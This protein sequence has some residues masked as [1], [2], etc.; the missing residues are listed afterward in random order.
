VQS[1]HGLCTWAGLGSPQAQHRYIVAPHLLSRCVSVL[2]SSSRT[3]RTTAAVTQR[4]Q[5][6]PITTAALGQAY[7][8][9]L[10]VTA[11]LGFKIIVNKVVSCAKVINVRLLGPWPWQFHMP[12]HT[13]RTDLHE[14]SSSSSSKC[15]QIAVQCCV[16]C[17]AVFS[18]SI[19]MLDLEDVADRCAVQVLVRRCCLQIYT[20]AHPNSAAAH[21]YTAQ[22]VCARG[23]ACS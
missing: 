4:S 17:F 18:A 9:R 15:K 5:R 23:A 16:Q 11:H 6:I 3:C 21:T 13:I 10:R 22:Q 7:M 2:H 20:H 19:V 14:N 12:S 1:Q 8:H